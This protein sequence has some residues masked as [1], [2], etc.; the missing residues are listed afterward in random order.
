MRKLTIMDRGLLFPLKEKK[1][2]RCYDTISKMQVLLSV[3]SATAGRAPLNCT[4][5]DY[6]ANRSSQDRTAAWWHRPTTSTSSGIVPTENLFHL[7]VLGSWIYCL[8]REPVFAFS[9]QCWGPKR[10]SASPWLAGRVTVRSTDT[11]DSCSIPG[12]RGF[13]HLPGGVL[14]WASSL[15][16]QEIGS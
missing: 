2:Q 4:S 5:C 11:T 10:V 6:T 3:S 9:Q 14:P 8:F 13:P 12:G 15:R 1:I 16:K 7:N